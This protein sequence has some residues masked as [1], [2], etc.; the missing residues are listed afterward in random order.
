M[1]KEQFSTIR[2]PLHKYVFS[3]PKT[4]QVLLCMEIIL[5]RMKAFLTRM[6]AVLAA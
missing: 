4:K 6:K 3:M 5:S 2:I 1:P